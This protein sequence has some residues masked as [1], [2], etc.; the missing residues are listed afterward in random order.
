MRE[1]PRR[2]RC[3]GIR[4]TTC[5]RHNL[6]DKASE[7]LAIFAP[8]AAKKML[9]EGERDAPADAGLGPA[10]RRAKHSDRRCATGH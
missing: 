5:A 6:L 10:G 3:K 8:D 4:N 9:A 7:I 2:R 1:R